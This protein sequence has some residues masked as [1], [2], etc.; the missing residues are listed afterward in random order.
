ML[1][2]QNHEAHEKTGVLAKQEMPTEESIEK[3]ANIFRVLSEPSRLKIVCALVKGELC[4]Y[5]IVKAVGAAQSAV[6]HQLRVL[7]DNGV[8][9]AKREGQSVVYSIADEHVFRILQTGLAHAECL[10]EAAQ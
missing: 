9:R 1:D 3:C 7:K 8:L 4:V 10:T 6:S 5:E 2:C